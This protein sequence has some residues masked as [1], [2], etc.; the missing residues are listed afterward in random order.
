[1][2]PGSLALFIFLSRYP[3][4]IQLA[5]MVGYTAAVIL[6]TFSA[7][8]GLP[9]YLFTCPVV[10]QQFYRLTV[11]HFGFLVAVFI[12]ETLALKLRSR[13]PPSWLVASG[14]NMPPFVTALFVLVGVLLLTEVMT[15]R[16]LLKRAHDL[17]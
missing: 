12:V 16:S 3:Y 5:S 7:N 9:R 2:M 14:K 15:N 11:R 6:Y 1:M 17:E 10:H 4:G 13:I 8:R